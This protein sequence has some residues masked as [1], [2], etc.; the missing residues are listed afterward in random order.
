MKAAQL[1]RYAKDYKLELRNVDTPHPN[2]SQVLVKVKE[3]AVNPLDSLIGTGSLRLI[4]NYRLPQ[5]MGN[6]LTGEIIEIGKDVKGFNV[7]D[8]VYARLPISDI[9]A[10]AEYVAINADAVAL[11]PETLD[12][13]T[14]AAAA[15]TGLTAYQ[16]LHEILNAHAG[17]TLFIP[18]GSGS[19]GQMAIPIA[20]QMGLT[21]FVNGGAEARERT[22]NAGADKYFDF[23]TENY[24]E[25]LSDVDLVIDTLGQNELAHELSILKRGG[26][27]LSLRMGPNGSFAEEQQM[28][29]WKK[30]LFKANGRKMDRLAKQHGVTYHFIF[31]RSDGKQLQQLSTLI[32]QNAIV[33]AVDPTIFN[34]EQVNEAQSYLRNGRPKGK[35]LIH[36][37]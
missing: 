5:T 33:P 27:L 18:G 9:G 8:K 12:F 37:N 30:L 16:A 19:F 21:V 14:G 13:K 24:W 35:V 25:K 7:N 15:L 31:V 22:L 26:Q 3:A 28:T 23:Q 6:E 10:F 32:D 17:Q 4:Q 29:T 20:K 11:L 36:F 2:H 34:I 1:T